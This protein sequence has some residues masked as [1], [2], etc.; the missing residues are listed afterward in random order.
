VSC[1][2]IRNFSGAIWLRLVVSY[3]LAE[4]VALRGTAR[5]RCRAI[6]AGIVCLLGAL[7][8]QPLPPHYLEY[9]N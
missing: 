3:F 6:P 5:D 2:K 1:M 7:G 8:R 9:S 4:E